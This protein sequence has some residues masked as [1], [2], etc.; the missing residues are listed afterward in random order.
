ME[1][2]KLVYEK[3]DSPTD[4]FKFCLDNKLFKEDSDDFTSR[5][6]KIYKT[7]ISN[8]GIS[9]TIAYINNE[10]IGICLLEHRLDIENNLYCCQAGRTHTDNRDRKNPWKAKYNFNFIHLGFLCFYVKDE[11]RNKGVAQEL[12]YEMEKLQLDR[13]KTAN[14]SED[15]KKVMDNNFLTVTVR[16]KARKV[17]AKSTVLNP[18]QGDI[19]DNCFKHDISHLTYDIVFD[20]KIDKKLGEIAP[21]LCDSQ[22]VITLETTKKRK[23]C[24]P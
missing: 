11:H 6:K 7:E 19:Q 22:N 17:L 10:P 12:L 2:E 1:I 14:L 21:E 18:M 16:G 8:C 4:L 3:D 15:V 5:M 24:L 20:E 13:L 23:T 9:A